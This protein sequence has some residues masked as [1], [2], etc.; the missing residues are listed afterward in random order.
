MQCVALGLVDIAYKVSLLNNFYKTSRRYVASVKA[1]CF[2]QN[3]YDISVLA[4]IGRS[5]QPKEEIKQ[6]KQRQFHH[7]QRS[8]FPTKS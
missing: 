1:K 5:F 8:S 2:V 3:P 6:Q 7:Q 4:P